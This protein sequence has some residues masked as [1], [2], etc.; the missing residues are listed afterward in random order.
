MIITTP[1]DVDVTLFFIL[2]LNHHK[3]NSETVSV[4]NPVSS[5][6]QKKVKDY[7]LLLL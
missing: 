7:V 5:R 2:T 3:C 6:G 4:I 1:V